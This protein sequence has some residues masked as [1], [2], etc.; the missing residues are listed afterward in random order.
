VVDSDG[1]SIR[2]D[3]DACPEHR[4]PASDDPEMN[5]CPKP[6][7]SDQDG[8]ADAYDACPDQAGE[9][10]ADPQTTGCAAELVHEDAE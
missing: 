5:G 9:A 3:L 1:D 6:K 7:D 4:G 8:V 10:S 2:D